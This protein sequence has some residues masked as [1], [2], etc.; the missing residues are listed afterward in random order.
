LQLY[1]NF[2]YCLYNQIKW[3][4]RFLGN[5]QYRNKV[6]VDGTDFRIRE[7]TEFNKKWYSHK[8]KAAG[9]RYEVAICIKTGN[10]VWVHGPYPCGS[11][12]DITIFR[13]GLK[14]A[15][16]QGEER[17]EADRGY[18]GEPLYIS[19]PDDC[20]NDD[21]KIAKAHARAR[22]EHVNRRLKEFSALQQVF[23]H[24]INKHATVFWLL[25]LLHSLL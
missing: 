6:T 8:F 11:N 7:P 16:Q 19:T 3:S 15:L 12:P 20:L 9:L 10:I 2:F 22:H 18:R 17:V 5:T 4:N 24:D 13:N 23:R 25:L 21:Q 14:Q 1:L